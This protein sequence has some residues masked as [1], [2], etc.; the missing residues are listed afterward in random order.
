[1]P[2]HYFLKDALPKN[3]LHERKREKSRRERDQSFFW[4]ELWQDPSLLWMGRHYATRQKWPSQI[5]P[6]L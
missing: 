1:M 2:T 4:D 3:R 5:S 6:W